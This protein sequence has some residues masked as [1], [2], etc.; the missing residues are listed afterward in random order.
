MGLEYIP[1]QP[2]QQ[3]SPKSEY[4]LV[5]D[6]TGKPPPKRGPQILKAITYIKNEETGEFQKAQL[7][8]KVPYPPKPKCKK[9]YGRGYQGLV[10]VGEQRGIIVCKKCYPML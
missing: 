4:V 6:V 3:A 7:E 10:T 9:C 2:E 1:K 8:F 5:K